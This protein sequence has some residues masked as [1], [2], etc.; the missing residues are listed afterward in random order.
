MAQTKEFFT[1][2]QHKHDIETNWSKAINFIPLAGE[3]IVY[4]K[5]EEHSSARIKIGDGVTKVSDL[6][7]NNALIAI[8]NYLHDNENGTGTVELTKYTFSE[9]E[10]AYKEGKNVIVYY[11][12]FRYLSV[13]RHINGNLWFDLDWPGATKIQLHFSSS[14]ETT[15]IFYNRIQYPE[16]QSDDFEEKFLKY[17]DGNAYWSKMNNS[18]WN[19]NDPEKDIYIKNRTHYIGENII[20]HD[21][22]LK[23]IGRGFPIFVDLNVTDGE[24][25]SVTVDGEKFDVI[26]RAVTINYAGQI[27][28]SG[29]A[30]GNIALMD[31]TFENTGESFIFAK[32]SPES[33]SLLGCNSIVGVFTGV[34]QIDFKIAK[35]E[36]HVLD[37][38]FL[39]ELITIEDIDEICG[40][41][42]I[43]AS[44]V[45]F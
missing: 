4:D 26:A 15:G 34:T 25:Y 42:I 13:S 23:Q 44:E 28:L 2:I 12:N 38:R 17:T 9:M 22:A 27:T 11:N 5:D 41:G 1:R 14:S 6:P 24:N 7:F 10:A 36:Y 29:V 30:M 31:P 45:K 18:D 3:I 35:E 16:A 39:P 37:M 20:F 40:A 19:E 8:A 21:P 43:A 33:A 32:L